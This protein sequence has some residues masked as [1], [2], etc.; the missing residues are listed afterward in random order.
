MPVY[1]PDGKYSSKP[2]TVKEL[3][4]K[5]GVG[6]Q[7]ATGPLPMFPGGDKREG[8]GTGKTHFL[9]CSTEMRVVAEGLISCAAVIY[10]DDDPDYHSGAWLHHAP[11]GNVLSTDVAAAVKGLGNP[12]KRCIYVVY[13]HPGPCGKGYN[14]SIAQITNYVLPANIVE[15]PELRCDFGVNNRFEIGGP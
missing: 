7:N 10:V 6:V 8:V 11:S 2:M 1:Q 14:S 3:F 9:P 5:F 4:L 12:R 15:I 13:A